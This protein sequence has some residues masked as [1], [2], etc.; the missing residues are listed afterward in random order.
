M[1]KQEEEESDVISGLCN[2]TKM[3]VVS[4]I[5]C[6]CDIQFR[7]REFLT[8]LEYPNHPYAIEV[9]KLIEAIETNTT[10]SS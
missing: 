2:E 3:K 4:A 6:Y 10:S 9:T 5:P 7:K 1:Q 8:V